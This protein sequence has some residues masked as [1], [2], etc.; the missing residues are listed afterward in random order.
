[1]SITATG[2]S[3]PYEAFLSCS[4][5]MFAAAV[6]QEWDT[7]TTLMEQRSQWESEI[8]RLRALDGPRQPLSP[9]QQEIFRRVLDL[10]HEVQDRVGPW[11]THAGKLLKS[12]GALPS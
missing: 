6:K 9:R 1:M 12:W 2:S 3:D 4:E 5:E 7:L 10:D 8:R 11:L